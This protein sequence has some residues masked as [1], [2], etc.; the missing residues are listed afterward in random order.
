[1]SVSWRV[2]KFCVSPAGSRPE[3]GAVKRDLRLRLA[4]LLAQVGDLRLKPAACLGVRVELGSALQRK[5][6]IGHFVR[7]GGCERRILRGEG[8]GDHTRLFDLVDLQLLFELLQHPFFRRQIERILLQAQHHQEIGR[9]GR[10][11]GGIELVEFV[12]LHV[13]RD[14]LDQ[15]RRTQDLHLAEDAQLV[16]H[17]VGAILRNLIGAAE[18][19]LARLNQDARL[20]LVIGSDHLGSPESDG[21]GPNRG[22]QHPHAALPDGAK[23]PAE[24]DI[25]I[26]LPADARHAC[27]PKLSRLAGR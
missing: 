14:L 27:T 2:A 24:I 13:A 23:K 8:D 9:G 6:D 18:L 11:C 25:H 3:L 21:S 22:E 7:N 15:V 17:P 4:H 5:I 10:P 12:K 19:G 1:M 16:E 26:L 20:A